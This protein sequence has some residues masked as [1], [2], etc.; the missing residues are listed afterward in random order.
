MVV[1]VFSWFLILLS[2]LCLSLHQQARL[3]ARLAQ[4]ETSGVETRALAYSGIEIAK[5]LLQRTGYN[6]WDAAIEGW[7][8]NMNLRSVP[9]KTGNISI[10]YADSSAEG[11]HSVYGIVDEERLISLDA[12]TPE[13]LARTPG[14]TS[15]GLAA[16]TTALA[17][18][19]THNPPIFVL[20][21][22]VD[23][24]TRRGLARVVSAFAVGGVNL[25]TT[26]PEVL[27]ALGVPPSAIEKLLAYRDGPDRQ[28]GTTDDQP[29][30][31]LVLPSGGLDRCGLTAEEAAPVS[32]LA[33]QAILTCASTT[34]HIHSRGWLPGH[35]DYHEIDAVLRRTGP[36]QV[37]VI[38]WQEAWIQ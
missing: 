32:S 31:S 17:A 20:P 1:V 10:G 11:Q 29:F 9:L 8:R 22:E 21:A 16:A 23:A 2:T 36:N 30:T 3:D 34:F 14:I 6:S 26:S 18:G 25:N 35:T 7:D 33:R 15:T 24:Q 13:F 12:L 38:A 4:H 37:A 27:V 19:R 28:P 5:S